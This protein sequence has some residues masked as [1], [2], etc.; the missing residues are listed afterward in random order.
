MEATPIIPS[1][2]MLPA[3]WVH[4]SCISVLQLHGCTTT[5]WV[6]SNYVCILQLHSCILAVQVQYSCMGAL[7]LQW[8]HCSC[9][10][11]LLYTI[12]QC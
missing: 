7:Q 11:A 1:S 2:Q 6:P 12:P 8:M 3:A 4:T 5:A 10:G 9:M